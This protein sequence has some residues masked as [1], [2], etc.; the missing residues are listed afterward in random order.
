MARPIPPDFNYRKELVDTNEQFIRDAFGMNVENWARF[1]YAINVGNESSNLQGTSIPND[2]KAA[3]RELGKCHYEVV[4]SLGYC[5]LTWLDLLLGNPFVLH[6]AVKDFYFH[7]GALLD[8]ISRLIYIINVPGA[9]SAKDR[10][11]T[12]LRHKIA[13]G[14]LIGNHSI[15]I[16]SYIPH[17]NSPIII[18]FSSLRNAVA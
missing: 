16:A 3:Y 4:C 2:V 18:E 10:K 8:N 15:H 6:K 1:R 12:H 17:V 13:R 7:G 14:S 11:G 5:N 9:A